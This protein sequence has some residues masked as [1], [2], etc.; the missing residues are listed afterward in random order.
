ME[1]TGERFVPAAIGKIHYE[2]VH[3]YAIAARYCVGKRVLDAAS[4]EG[5]SAALLAQGAAAVIGVSIDAGPI[6]NARRSY[7]SS[8]LRFLQGS[9]RRHSLERLHAEFAAQTGAELER[10]RV[11]SLALGDVLHC[12]SW[13]VTKPTRLA[14]QQMCNLLRRV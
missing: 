8:K 4:G 5:Y 12:T 6:A 2:R 1:F 14:V 13:K 10:L 9:V 7:Y 3:P 11:D